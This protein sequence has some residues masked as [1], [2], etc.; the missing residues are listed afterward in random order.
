MNNNFG[1]KGRAES[2][3]GLDQKRSI[4]WLSFGIHALQIIGHEVEKASTGSEKLVLKFE[5]EPVTDDPDFK[6]SDDSV[7]GGKTAKAAV[8][9]YIT[10]DEAQDDLMDRLSLIAKHIGRTAEIDA[11]GGDAT[12]LKEYLDAAVPTLYNADFAYFKLKGKEYVNKKGKI[13]VVCELARYGFVKG[14]AEAG[15]IT[16][17]DQ[18]FITSIAPKAGSESKTTMTFDKENVYDYEPVTESSEG[19]DPEERT[20]GGTPAAKPVW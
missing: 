16:M 9:I 14:A 2:A 11:A 5:G 4:N 3:A 17:N 1:T 19:A 12:T 6:P 8:S 13:G 20:T 7:N 18:G 10:T 15:E